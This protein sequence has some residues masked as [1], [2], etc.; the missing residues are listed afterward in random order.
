MA[1]RRHVEDRV[2]LALRRTIANSVLTN[3]AIARKAGLGVVDA[4]VLN[5]LGLSEQAMT[6]GE[7]GAAA[8]LP[9]STTTRVIDRLERAGYVRRTSDPADRR[10]VYVQAVP[11]RLAALA[12]EYDEISAGMK[13]VLS[14]FSA[15]QLEIVA[16]F[17]EVITSPERRRLSPRTGGS[18]G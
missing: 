3:D 11:E 1:R 18:P 6:A 4:Q 8:G 9:S 5:L 15:Q 14:E 13:E 7:L 2:L 10:R 12:G 17:L 16:Q